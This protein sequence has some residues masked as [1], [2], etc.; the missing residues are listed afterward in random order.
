LYGARNG[1]RN[2]E[3]NCNIHAIV[4]L[5]RFTAPDAPIRPKADNPGVRY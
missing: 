3:A 5:P 2:G 4:E 1:A